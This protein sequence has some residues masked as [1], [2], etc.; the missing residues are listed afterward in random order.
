MQSSSVLEQ[1]R[2]NPQFSER[3]ADLTDNE[4][5]ALQFDWDTW[6]RP[7]QI[8]PSWDWATWL[9]LAGRGYGKTRTGAETVRL[10]IRAGF[11][12]STIRRM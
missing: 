12:H 1:L 10:W 8:A 3:L 2:K 5:Q 11:N 9:I 7:N 6:A 4:L